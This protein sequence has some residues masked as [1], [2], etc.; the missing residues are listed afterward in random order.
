MTTGRHWLEPESS[1]VVLRSWIYQKF[2]KQVDKHFLPR[3][4]YIVLQTS[5][6][7]FKISSQK[8]CDKT[9]CR[10]EFWSSYETLDNYSGTIFCPLKTEISPFP[11]GFRLKHGLP[12]FA[13]H[14]TVSAMPLYRIIFIISLYHSKR[15]KKCWRHLRMFW[16]FIW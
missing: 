6:R 16:T 2:D 9:R 8:K 15:G 12:A 3:A 1:Q 5:V 14:S 13:Y 11:I 7:M 4:F 10:K